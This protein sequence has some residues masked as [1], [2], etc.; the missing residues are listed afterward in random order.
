M[1][2]PPGASLRLTLAIPTLGCGGAQRVLTALANRWRRAGHAV[3]VLALADADRTPFFSLDC[4]VRVER[5]SAPRDSRHILDAVV[6]NVRRLGALRSALQ[7]SRPD[8]VLSFLPTA[9]VLTLLTTA[10]RGTPVAVSERG[11]PERQELAWEWRLLRRLLYPRAAAVVVQTRRAGE[12]FSTGLQARATV[13]PN[14]VARPPGIRPRAVTRPGSGIVLGVGR[15]EREK[16]FD[17]LIAAFAQA[18]RDHGGWELV[19]AGIGSERGALAALADESGVGN[20][21]RL[22]GLRADIWPLYAAADVFALPSRHEGFPNALL[23]A[24]AAGLPVVA[25]DC[26]NGPREIITDE[27]DGLLT[28]AG[29]VD[30]LAHALS[31]LIGDAGLRRR[32]G[33]AATA[34]AARYGVEAIGQ[35]WDALIADVAGRARG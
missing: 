15:L 28:P 27:C 22:I 3:T 31:R 32:L 29:D 30:A 14:A 20:R 34:V 23:E 18:A 35:R 17:L 25:A 24:M 10:G 8:L 9:S 6:S 11:N 5:L 1:A 16:G 13:I 7:R 26:P 21:V 4:G 12:W 19:I 2:K 33:G